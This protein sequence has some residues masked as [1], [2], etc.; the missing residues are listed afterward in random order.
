VPS[1]QRTVLHV[2]CGLNDRA[3]LPGELRSDPWREI[4]VDID[5]AVKPD[6]IAN[7][8]DLQPVADGM[9]DA[10]FSSH[11]LE[12][13]YAHE[14]EPTL[15]SFH[16]VTRPDGFVVLITPDLQWICAQVA[17]DRLDDV[18]YVSPSGPIAPIDMLFGFRP[19]IAKGN[20]HYAHRTGFT[21]KTLTAA[22]HAAGFASIEVRQGARADLCAVAWKT[23]ARPIEHPLPYQS[24]ITTS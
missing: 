17:Q 16:R 11:N 23:G 2:G 3:H 15:R 5:P 13:L 24:G 9:A 10:V 20:T 4:R 14:V 21:R 1:P 8:V 12:H 7:I 18:L 22:F 19:F 6:I